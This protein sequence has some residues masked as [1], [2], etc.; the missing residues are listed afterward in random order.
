MD[1]YSENTDAHPD[2]HVCAN[3]RIKDIHA[4]NFRNFSDVKA[5]FSPA[6]NVIGGMN[7]Q[8][9][10][11]LLESILLAL[12][13]KSHRETMPENFIGSFGESAYIK[14]NAWDTQAC[15]TE[16]TVRL[17]GEKKIAVNGEAVKSRAQ[18]MQRFSVIFFGPDDLGI[19]KNG[20]SARRAFLDE[21]IALVSFAYAQ[22]ITDYAKVLRQRNALL[23]ESF[24][25]SGYALLDVYDEKLASLGE[26]IL[27]FR[28]R[29]LKEF[30][31]CVN[32]NYKI[33]SDA[34]EDISLHY[35]TDMQVYGKEYGERYLKKLRESRRED[36][37]AKTTGCG[38]HRDDMLIAL[39]G[40][41]AR[42]FASQG[43]QRS[44]SI[45]LKLS[46]LSMIRKIRNCDTL[47]LLDDVMSE[48]DAAR[49][50]R[51]CEMLNGIQ[52]FITCVDSGFADSVKDKKMF[53]VHNGT[54]TT[55]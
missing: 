52:T 24:G 4:V 22:L 25:P 48:L 14:I 41:D 36:I 13:G 18:L 19:V 8:G 40:R 6:M 11:N 47:V 28:I 55:D 2:S 16:V 54:V 44:A 27:F 10:T 53:I 5:E 23:K 30:S 1:N 29:F 34:N 33:I 50:R 51:I 17:S 37:L 38:I 3:M 45:C 7:A 35:R 49:Q 43:Q 42:K 46:M 39:D 32:E 31:A 12:C 21:S 26:K 20:P 9:K 15:D